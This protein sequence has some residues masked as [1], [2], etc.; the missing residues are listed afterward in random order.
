MS[1]EKRKKGGERGA[2]GVERDRGRLPIQY[3]QSV[4]SVCIHFVSSPLPRLK[5]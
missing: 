2:E 1:E 5:V 3:D 4:C